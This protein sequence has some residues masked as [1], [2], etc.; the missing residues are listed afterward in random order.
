MK[1]EN[2]FPSVFAGGLNFELGKNSEVFGLRKFKK[3]ESQ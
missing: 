1:C 2:S 3:E